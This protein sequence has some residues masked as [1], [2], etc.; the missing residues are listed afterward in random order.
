ML[1][2]GFCGLRRLDLYL[3]GSAS[4]ALLF[5]N[6][7]AVGVNLERLSLTVADRHIAGSSA[8]AMGETNDLTRYI[9][10][11]EELRLS[12]FEFSTLYQQLPQV[13]NFNQLVRLELLAS[14]GGAQHLLQ[15]LARGAESN[16]LRV[17]HIAFESV[18]D[19]SPDEES[20]MHD[21]F[22][23]ML[24]ACEPIDSF[25]ILHRQAESGD[26]DL[27]NCLMQLAT[28]KYDLQSLSFNYEQFEK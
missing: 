28:R 16:K 18:G 27:E 7:K 11:L 5:D 23:R 13:A 20:E 6:I 10:R 17:K 2:Q 9:P 3:E 24:E 12:G 25:N 21:S 22:E 26:F 1:P 14:Q 4:I 8:W 19:L 15:H